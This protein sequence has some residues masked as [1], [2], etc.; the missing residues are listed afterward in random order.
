M[1][2]K[3]T[4]TTTITKTLSKRHLILLE[5]TENVESSSLNISLNGEEFKFNQP[6]KIVEWNHFLFWPVSILVTLETLVLGML[7]LRNRKLRNPANIFVFSLLVSD[8]FNGA[9][10]LP[11]ILTVGFL[12][13]FVNPLIMFVLSSSF[14]NIF[15]CT[16]DRFYGVYYALNYRKYMTKSRVRKTLI[17]LWSVS[18]FLSTLPKVLGP[19]YENAFSFRRV[20][21]SVIISTIVL[22]TFVVFG[23]YVYIFVVV[24]RQLKSIS[25]NQQTVTT[26][27]SKL[28]RKNKLL[29]ENLRTTA[30]ILTL[31][32]NFFVCWFPLIYINLMADVLR[33][34]EFVP[35][36]M[37]R[38][39]LYTVFFSSLMNPLLYGYR[40]KTIRNI[41]KSFVL[42]FLEKRFS[43]YFETKSAKSHV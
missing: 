35:E 9:I 17:L 22:M 6:I 5:M 34:P 41:A 15:T 39:S 3:D 37:L 38:I 33:C 42:G 25:L 11:L 13:P 12:H 7:I 1:K 10:L 4:A 8:F 16:L 19:R 32:L 24:R 40:Q 23:V 27:C 20:Y 26:T 31:N 30:T 36:F 14:L 29:K 2:I 21:L 28:E 18:T 43:I